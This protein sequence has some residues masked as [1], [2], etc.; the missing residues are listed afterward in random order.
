MSDVMTDAMTEL[1]ALSG[2]EL[3]RLRNMAGIANLRSL[4]GRPTCNLDG[5]WLALAEPKRLAVLAVARVSAA[6]VADGLLALPYD[7]REALRLAVQQLGFQREFRSGVDRAL[8][9]RAA[10]QTGAATP[11][12]QRAD[13]LT[14]RRALLASG[15]G[16]NMQPEQAAGQ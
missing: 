12:Q 14:Q 6:E 1:A 2:D 4:F 16:R 5:E 8:W 7:Q 3:Q 15:A 9:H 13:R 11:A 10:A